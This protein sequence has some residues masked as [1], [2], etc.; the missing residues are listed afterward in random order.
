MLADAAEKCFDKPWLEDCIVDMVGCGMRERETTLSYQMNQKAN[1][2]VMTPFG[3]TD[4]IK[5]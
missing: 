3:E 2:K 5:I 1:I 4:E